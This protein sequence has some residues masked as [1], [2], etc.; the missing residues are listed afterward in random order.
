MFSLPE[1]LPAL[2]RFASPPGGA[3]GLGLP[4]WL[5]DEI[6]RRS[7]NPA[8]AGLGESA[9]RFIGSPGVMSTATLPGAPARWVKSRTGIVV[10][11]GRGNL[12]TRATICA[13]IFRSEFAVSR[14][15]RSSRGGGSR[16]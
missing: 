1:R 13:A 16:L 6:A 9:I 11:G 5:A 7:L 14:F 10:A 12:G 2:E 8:G 15:G 3:G 4:P